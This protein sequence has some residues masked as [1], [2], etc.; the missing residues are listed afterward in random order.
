MIR[1]DK[2]L[3]ELNI[4]SRSEASKRVK[5]GQVKINGETAK[6]AD[7][8]INEG[9]DVVTFCD[10][11]IVYEK[12]VYFMLNKPEGYV[13]AT[14]D[15]HDK[16]V[17]DLFSGENFKGLF[18]VGRLDKDTTGLLIIT[19]DGELGHRLTGPKFEVYKE[20]LATLSLKLSEDAVKKLENGV[21]IGEGKLTKPCRVKKIDDKTILISICEGKFHQVKRMLKAVNN[22]VLTLKRLS[23]GNVFLDKELKPGEYRRLTSDE[24]SILKGLSEVIDV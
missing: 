17:I 19:N 2:F 21:D 10:R 3:S 5:A 8:K 24:I 20:Y 6:A 23:M 1:L 13:S 18:P 16:T 9:L 12:F 7:V 14:K 11:Q 15:N 4:C 22:E